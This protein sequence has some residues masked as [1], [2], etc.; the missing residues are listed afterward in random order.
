[1]EDILLGGTAAIGGCRPAASRP[2]DDRSG[3]EAVDPTIWVTEVIIDKNAVIN[4]SRR[5]R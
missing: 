2:F 5:G 1:M 3:A 4:V